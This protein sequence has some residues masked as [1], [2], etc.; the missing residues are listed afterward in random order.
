MSMKHA[1]P[2]LTEK[3]S[4]QMPLDHLTARNLIEQLMSVVKHACDANELIERV[5]AISW[6][7]EILKRRPGEKFP[8]IRLRLEPHEMDALKQ[9]GV[10]EDDLCLTSKLAN[11][12]LPNGQPMTTLEKLLYS[13]L[14]K[15]GDLGK[16]HH[17]VAGVL[18]QD[19]HQKTGTVFYEF[20]GYLS[21]RN[22]FIIDQHTLRCFAVAC[23]KGEAVTQAR[24]LEL[25]DR[26]HQKH[27]A[28]IK[29]YVAFYEE[30]QKGK[31]MPVSDYLYEVDRLLFGA[32]KLIKLQKNQG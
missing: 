24:R 28:W 9:S 29:S 21:G 25:I 10:I 4:P 7:D 27:A 11:G 8:R 30:I 26:N 20:G 2:K 1:T 22:N 3:H 31:N 19:V 17:I 6:G 15:N 13:V 5:R 23:E 12:V 16:E 18:E 32:G 14:W